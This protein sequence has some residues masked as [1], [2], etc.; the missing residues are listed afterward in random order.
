MYK[1]T[2]DNDGKPTGFYIEEVHGDAIPSG[3]VAI[4]DIDH[5]AFIHEHGK[6]IWRNGKR[7]VAPPAEPAPRETLMVRIRSARNKLLAACDW[8][9]LVDAQ[10]TAEER[11]KWATYRQKLRD[12]PATCNPATPVWP[13]Q[14]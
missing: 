3:A 2:F 8:T 11:E 10:L 4:S 13:E 14:P 7:V 6:W 1:A 5:D 9:Q 12:F